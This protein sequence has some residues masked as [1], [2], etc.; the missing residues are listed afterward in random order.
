MPVKTGDR[1]RPERPSTIPAANA[2]VYL[3]DPNKGYYVARKG[4][5]G[6]YASLGRTEWEW[7]EFRKISQRDSY[8]V[9]GAPRHFPSLPGFSCIARLREIHRRADQNYHNRQN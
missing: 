4:S 9:E 2:A 7:G 3:L 8:D 1:L 6:S 5:N